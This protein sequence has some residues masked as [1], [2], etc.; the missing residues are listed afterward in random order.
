MASSPFFKES[1]PSGM[2]VNQYMV[3]LQQSF[4]KLWGILP[5]TFWLLSNATLLNSNGRIHQA[6]T[7]EQQTK[8]KTIGMRYLQC[9]HYLQQQEQHLRA[10]AYRVAV[11]PIEAP[12]GFWNQLGW[13]L[14]GK[15]HAQRA[16]DQQVQARL[17]EAN[18]FVQGAAGENALAYV[19]S[20]QLDDSWVLLQGYLPPP[21]WHKGGDLDALL[22][23]R[24]GI[25]L[26]EAKTWKG[27]FLHRSDEWYYQRHP[28]APWE[29][30][31]SNPTQQA[32][33]NAA[34]LQHVL[35]HLHLSHVPVRP[36]IALVSDRMRVSLDPSMPPLVP[37][38]TVTPYPQEI[39]RYLGPPVLSETHID[40]VWQALLKAALPE[41]RQ[42]RRQNPIR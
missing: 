15:Q 27:F 32:T 22:I 38:F 29:L 2:F 26:F 1:L 18:Q 24:S 42:A 16:R 20:R 14:G 23:G 8:E 5:C 41:T 3:T 37:L 19:L 21:P 6:H 39:S 11:T 10:E 30:A 28:N 33:K 13:Y 35:A 34:R 25:T 40:Q 17:A 4:T 9:S 12:S 7:S 36:L 31:R